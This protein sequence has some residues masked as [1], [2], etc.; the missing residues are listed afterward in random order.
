MKEIDVD[1]VSRIQNHK[2]HSEFMICEVQC[3]IVKL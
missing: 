2:V 1:R 3:M